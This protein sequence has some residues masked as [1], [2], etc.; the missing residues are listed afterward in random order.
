[1]GY[2]IRHSFHLNDTNLKICLKIYV[3][4]NK[5]QVKLNTNDN[6]YYLY[7]H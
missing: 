5:K 6:Y 4:S 1:M 2:F 7:I 3:N